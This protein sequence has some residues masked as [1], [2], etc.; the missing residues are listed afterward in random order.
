MLNK[1]WY[2][3]LNNFL[4][5]LEHRWREVL[6]IVLAVI[7]FFSIKSCNNN[8]QLVRDTQAVYAYDDSIA[9]SK[10]RTWIDK[11]SKEHKTVENLVV[12]REALAKQVDSISSV[13]KIKEKQ[14]QRL[15]VS[16]NKIEIHEKL[17]VDTFYK[18]VPCDDADSLIIANNYQFKWKDSWMEASGSIGGDKDSI[19]ISGVD[20]L[21]RVDYWKR[22]WFLGAK[23]YYSDFSNSNKHIKLANNKSVQFRDKEKK[24]SIGAGGGI[25][26]PINAPV[27]FKKPIVSVGLFFQ[28][29]IVRF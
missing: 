2:L 24:W 14:I 9:N 26:Y 16:V 11:Y 23:H 25:S 28:R 27:N 7:L 8:K 20:T 22:K 12:Q 17:K 3:K 19:H 21:N 4:C 13:L 18:K 15:S 10:I 6:I 5:W 1:N 29:D